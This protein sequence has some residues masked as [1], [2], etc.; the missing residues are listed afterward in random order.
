MYQQSRPKSTLELRCSTHTLSSKADTL[1]TCTFCR[2]YKALSLALADRLHYL[3]NTAHVFHDG[4][5]DSVSSVCRDVMRSWSRFE[6]ETNELAAERPAQRRG[7]STAL[8]IFHNGRLRIPRLHCRLLTSWTTLWE[9][10]E[11]NRM[12]L[13]GIAKGLKGSKMWGS[14]DSNLNGDK[15]KSA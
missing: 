12:S 14:N 1:I 13:A 3:A 5:S 2:S 4:N 15:L 11:W 9:V 7:S 10:G 8:R 6:G